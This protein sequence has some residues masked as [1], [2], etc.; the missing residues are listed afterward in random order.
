MASSIADSRHIKLA[1]S[2][3]RT[4]PDPWL[5]MAT[6]GRRHRYDPFYREPSVPIR[7]VEPSAPSKIRLE[8]AGRDVTVAPNNLAVLRRL[9]ATLGDFTD[10]DAER[11]L[12][13]S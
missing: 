5:E 13:V 9:F 12:L 6:V 10:A 11:L 3:L 4:K 7:L 2:E 8:P 1:I